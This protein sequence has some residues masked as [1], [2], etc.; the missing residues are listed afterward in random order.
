MENT[1]SYLAVKWPDGKSAVI[2]L[3]P[4]DRVVLIHR[5]MLTLD[6]HVEVAREIAMD[7]VLPVHFTFSGQIIEVGP[8][9][10]PEEIDEKFPE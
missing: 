6:A 2:T 9:S 10:T 4:A 5:Y 1:T 3:H 8:W 7:H